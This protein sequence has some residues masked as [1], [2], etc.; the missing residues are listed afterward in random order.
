MIVAAG[1]GPHGPVIIF[2]LS[3]ENVRR[4]RAGQPIRTEMP[5]AAATVIIFGGRGTE[6]DLRAQLAEVVEL[7]DEED[8]P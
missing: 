5:G 7:P 4:M 2:G 3:E 8:R 6:D 1:E